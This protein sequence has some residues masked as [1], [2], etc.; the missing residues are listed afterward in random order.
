METVTLVDLG[1]IIAAILGPM[2]ACMFVLMRYQHRDSVETRKLISGLKE[3]ISEVKGEITGVKGEI[4]GVREET[5]R[6]ISESNR[7]I[8][9][10]VTG[11]LE[12]LAD[13]LSAELKE[14]GRGLADARERLAR[15]E[16]HLGIGRFPP[17]EE[18][19]A[20]DSN[21]A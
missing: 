14:L 12:R 18:P 7:E 4:T 16:G 20:P 21:A 6:L 1:P 15:I 13:R 9:E 11:Q 10:W 5:R 2:L 19:G 8:R 17:Q 3:E